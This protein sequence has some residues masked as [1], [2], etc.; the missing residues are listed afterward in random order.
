MVDTTSVTAQKKWAIYAPGFAQLQDYRRSWIRGDVVAGITVAAYLIPQVMAYATLAGLPPV[1]G[2]WASLAPLAIYAALGSSRRL[3]VG[4]ESTSALMTAVVLAP[5]AQGDPVRYASLAAALAILVGALCLLAGLVRLGILANLLS[6]PVL[7]GYMAGIG[8]TMIG[9]QI[10]TMTRT[11]VSGD[12]FLQQLES[13]AQNLS[14]VHWPTLALSACVLGLLIAL[15]HWVPRAPG[16]LLAVLAAAAAVLLFPSVIP[17]ID[18]VGATAAG[19]PNPQFPQAG[20]QMS[21]SLL[22]PA[23]AVAIVAFSDN[24]LTARAFAVRDSQE[25]DANTELRALGV[26]NI[27]AGLTQGFP[28]SSS[29]SRTALG[30]ATGSRS[31]LNSLVTLTLILVV[32]MF[33]P[34]LL[35]LFPRAALGALVVYAAAK[36]IDLSE[37]RRF[38]RFRRSELVLALSTTLGVLCLGVLNGIAFAVALSILDLLRRVAHPHDSVLGFVAGIPGMHDVDD[39]PDAIA[40]PGLVVYR[41]D[42]PLC[43]ANAEDFRRRA[44]T[45]VAANPTPVEWFVLNAEAN[46]EV[47]LTA[48]D[49]LDAL[50]QNLQDKKIVFAM[51]RVKQDLRDA[52]AAADLLAKIGDEHIFLTLPSAVEAFNRR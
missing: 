44:L 26:C 38:A 5:L 52:L 17:G 1:A 20:L 21:A 34:G 28:V 49:A 48:L 32:L 3:S 9:S 42:A 6:R 29:G 36:L 39:Y 24:I 22:V 19:L 10:G 18:L 37:Y 45:A 33:T 31:Q 25:V 7:I 46:V 51:A 35:A 11:Q 2:I 50:R 30:T 27:G 8:I 4:P 47:D 41:Y 15:A 13:G 40:P 12:A 14:D 43:F 23:I 16:A